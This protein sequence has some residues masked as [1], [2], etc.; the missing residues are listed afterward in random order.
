MFLMDSLIRRCTRSI[1]QE[2]ETVALA[3]GMDAASLAQGI[4]A[5]RIVIPANPKR[6][7]R[8]CAILSL[9]HI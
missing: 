4:A 7:H 9:I 6:K 1:P 2:L 5:G 3:E 8:Q